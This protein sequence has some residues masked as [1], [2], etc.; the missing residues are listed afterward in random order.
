MR[1]LILQPCI[2]IIGGANTIVLKVARFLSMKGNHVEIWSN[3][4]YNKSHP[5]NESFKIKDISVKHFENSLL[6][7]RAFGILTYLFI[8]KEVQSFDVIL[9]HNFPSNLVAVSR[10]CKGIPII[11]HCHEPSIVLFPLPKESQGVHAQDFF[12]SYAFR[13]FVVFLRV[14]DKISIRRVSRIISLNRYVSKRIKG[15]YC[16]QSFTI[17]EGIDTRRFRPGIS[18]ESIRLKHNIQGRP[19]ILYVGALTKRVDLLL[20]AMRMLKNKIRD[21]VLLLVGPSY[22]KH[23]EERLRRLIANHDIEDNVIFVGVAGE[24][25]LPMYY[26]ACDVFVFPHPFWSWSLSTLEAMACGKAVVVPD[27]CGIS[28]IIRDGH[29]GIKV[30]MTNTKELANSIMNLLNNYALRMKIGDNAR[31]FV[32]LNLDHELFVKSYL[33]YIELVVRQNHAAYLSHR[34]RT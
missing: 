15:I 22:D 14:L 33:K 31:S 7:K 34:R 28:E 30:S 10:R 17:M 20:L 6:L 4:F 19:C 29:N 18:N 8:R 16:R 3:F 21:V 2:D 25:F 26:S 1:I 24:E 11:W 9:C 12:F 32:E 5:F 23:A 13:P 27:S